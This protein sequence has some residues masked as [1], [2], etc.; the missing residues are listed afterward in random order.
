VPQ[1]GILEKLAWQILKVL[2]LDTFL[3]SALSKFVFVPFCARTQDVS[4]FPNHSKYCNSEQNSASETVLKAYM[5]KYSDLD[6][7]VVYSTTRVNL[8]NS[9]ATN[10]QNDPRSALEI[11]PISVLLELV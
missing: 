9:K 5:S 3:T 1:L 6:H 7:Y 4:G 8:T 2:P 10:T 11:A